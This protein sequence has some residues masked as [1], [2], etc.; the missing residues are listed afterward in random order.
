MSARSVRFRTA[1]AMRRSKPAK[2]E[3]PSPL[4]T[5][6]ILHDTGYIATTSPLQ[7][8][9]QQR[10]L[11]EGSLFEYLDYW[12]KKAKYG[13]IKPTSYDT[14]ERVIVSYIQPTIGS[15]P[16]VQ[17]TPDDIQ[18]L[19]TSMREDEGYSYST[20]KKVF[21]CLNEALRYAT[22]RKLVIDNPMLLV[23]MP[24]S[25]LFQTKEISFFSIR[26]C[27]RIMEEAM[28][29]YSTGRRV[30]V[31]GDAFIL[32]LLTGLRLG[33]LIGLTHDDY[34]LE[35]RVLKVRR[36][37]HK[38]RK[39]DVDGKL[40]PGRD[41]RIANT[42]KSYSGRRDIPLPALAVAAI[43]RMMSENPL[44]TNLVCNSKGKMATPEQIDR[45]FHTLLRNSGLDQSGVH[46]LRHTYASILFG[47]KK[48]DIKTISK[49]MGHASPT[50]T[51]NI[52]T[53]IADRIPHEAVT[54]LDELF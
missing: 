18:G 42:T 23:E 44:R 41:L 54:P 21:T 16:L 14:I 13:T 7:I 25:D 27:E 46:K 49:L 45:T 40:M 29:T 38:V 15:I 35:N 53:H 11:W 22:A 50:I 6:L 3:L 28:R 32:L 31:Y 4:S 33:E 34:D 47:S 30:Y 8:A 52:Y 2:A 36:T 12:L 51:L 1:L 17:L 26:E 24:S 5:P 48:V 9:I 37:V 10:P 19:M 43:E 39:R 20:V